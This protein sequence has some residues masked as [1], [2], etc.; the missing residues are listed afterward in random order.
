MKRAPTKGSPKKKHPI[1]VPRVN[2]DTLPPVVCVNG[3]P[4]LLPICRFYADSSKSL[5]SFPNWVQRKYS[6]YEFTRDDFDMM[7]LVI[8]YTR[9]G[10]Y[11]LACAEEIVQARCYLDS[12]IK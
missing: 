5:K 2:A 4:N 11:R 12:S 1:T 9:T 6:G 3:R 7:M 8:A 10:S